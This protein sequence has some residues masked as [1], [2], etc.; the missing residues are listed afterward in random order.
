MNRANLEGFPNVKIQSE[1]RADG[2]RRVRLAAQSLDQPEMHSKRV[3]M[4]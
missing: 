4:C 2:E 1:D 3:D